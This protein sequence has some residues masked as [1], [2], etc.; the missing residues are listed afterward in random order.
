[1]QALC[2]AAATMGLNLC[3]SDAFQLVV[4]PVIE[5]QFVEYVSKHGKS[6]ATAEE[7]QFRLEQFALTHSEIEQISAENGSFTVGHNFM[8]D[9]THE[10]YKKMLGYK[11]PKTLQAK[12]A[13]ELDTKALPA[14]VDWRTMGAVNA[15]KNQ[16]QCGS[17]WAFSATCAIEGAH[18]RA[19]GTLLSLAEQQFVDCDTSSYG[20]NGGW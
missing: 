1:M 12:P 9:W 2:A 14:S 8:S 19:T 4:S 13:V 3:N 20:C 10:E 15:V 7:Y 11:A 16:G 18:F 5:Q 17:C 6:Y